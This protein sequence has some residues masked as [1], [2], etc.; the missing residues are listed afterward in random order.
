MRSA[1][2]DAVESESLRKEKQ[3]RTG[4]VERKLSFDGAAVL[5]SGP[6]SSTLMAVSWLW[7]IHEGKSALRTGNR[8]SCKDGYPYP[9][10]W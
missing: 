2:A 9:R 8:L 10:T 7:L 1:S 3:E 5:M 6:E 4:K